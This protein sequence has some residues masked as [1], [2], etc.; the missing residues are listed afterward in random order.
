MPVKPEGVELDWQLTADGIKELTAK[1][2]EREKKIYDEI[3][4]LSKEDVNMD[5]LLYVSSSSI[6]MY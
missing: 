3:G 6:C 5:N 1:L 4:A 2:I